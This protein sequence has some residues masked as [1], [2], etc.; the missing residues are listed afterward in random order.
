MDRPSSADM[1]RTV[2]VV[3]GVVLAWPG[4]DV[5]GDGGVVGGER[6]GSLGTRRT[7]CGVFSVRKY[8]WRVSVMAEWVW[9][10]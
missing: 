1:T 4:R 5:W 10:M 3:G 9:G 6:A 2:I 7:R 8:R